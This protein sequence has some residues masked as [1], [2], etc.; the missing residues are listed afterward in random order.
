MLAKDLTAKT[1]SGKQVLCT[2]KDI[3]V[4]SAIEHSIECISP[5]SHEEA[6]ARLLL[7]AFDAAKNGHKKVV[8]KTVDSHV[9]VIALYAFPH[10]AVKE[11]WIE[12]GTGKYLQFLSIH[13]LYSNLPSGVPDL[14]PFFMPSQ[15]AT[16][17]H[18][19]AVFER[20]VRGRPGCHFAKLIQPSMSIQIFHKQ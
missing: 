1:R 10:M 19:F 5:S 17:C 4:A 3:V 18:R 2:C 15:D 14:M 7:H 11:L 20:K 9:V 8:I 6:D 16:L 13:E 12:Y